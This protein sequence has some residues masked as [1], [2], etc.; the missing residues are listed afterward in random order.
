MEFP[1]TAWVILPEQNKALIKKILVNFQNTKTSVYNQSVL[2]TS[3]ICHY[4]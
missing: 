1:K 2:Q 3:K 4:M